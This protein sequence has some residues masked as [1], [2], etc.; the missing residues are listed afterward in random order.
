MC[1]GP[2]NAWKPAYNKRFQYPYVFLNELPFDD[3]FQ[4]A[5]SGVTQARTLYGLISQEHWSLP[6]WLSEEEFGDGP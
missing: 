6:E 3:D 5:T 4:A 2:C 1:S